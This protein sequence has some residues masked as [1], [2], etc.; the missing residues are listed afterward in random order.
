MQLKTAL[1][2]AGLMALLAGAAWAGDEPKKEEHRVTIIC[3]RGPGG[4]G[5]EGPEHGGPAKHEMMFM[6]M[7]ADGKKLDANGDGTITREE[8]LAFHGS[9]FDEMD[10]NHDGKLSADEMHGDM[11]PPPGG[12]GE[13]ERM[14]I[15]R[16]HMGGDMQCSHEGGPGGDMA[17]HVEHGD[18]KE[19]RVIVDGPDGHMGE[20]GERAEHLRMMMHDGHGHG[21]GFDEMDKNKDGKLTFDEF[22]A[23]M[24][25]AF[26]H[27][28]KNHDGVVDKAE[29]GE[30]HI[31]IRRIEKHVEKKTED[32]K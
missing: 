20:H 2:G 1:M 27:M 22:A 3:H 31:M 32:K 4:P 5:H 21:G 7:H 17:V 14:M 29:W 8:F 26:A 9:M 10:K 6:R 23:P 12:P 19:V 30:G 11:P 28:D 18:G 13:H 24:H 16:D 25:D 15:M